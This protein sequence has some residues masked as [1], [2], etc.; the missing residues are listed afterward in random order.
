[1]VS[2]RG[3]DFGSVVT[4]RSCYGIRDS[5]RGA[6]KLPGAIL[7][8]LKWLAVSAGTLGGLTVVIY[9]PRAKVLTDA[10]AVHYSSAEFI[11]IVL[12][13]LT[14]FNDTATTEIYT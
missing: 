6:V 11:T 8:G 9:V 14:F 1:M 13:A 4:L 3:I 7:E 2:A 10:H 12:T 5:G